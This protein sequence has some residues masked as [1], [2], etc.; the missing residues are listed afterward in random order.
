MSIDACDPGVAEPIQILLDQWES[1]CTRVRRNTRRASARRVFG[2]AAKRGSIYRWGLAVA[3]SA[4]C[5]LVSDQLFRLAVGELGKRK[6]RGQVEFPGAAESL[7]QW[8]EDGS[9][10]S[11]S[12]ALSVVTWSA[13]LPALLDALEPPAWINLYESILGFR[14]SVLQRGQPASVGQL[15]IGAELGLTLA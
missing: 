15:M 8:L 11:A 1:V 9:D 3:T 5:D 12:D 14:E 2:D 6:Q 13:A 4:D 7:T 10:E